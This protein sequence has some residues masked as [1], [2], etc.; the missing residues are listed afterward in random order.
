MSLSRQSIALVGLLATENKETK[1]HIHPE[2]AREQ[3]TRPG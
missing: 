3:K 2:H 1:H